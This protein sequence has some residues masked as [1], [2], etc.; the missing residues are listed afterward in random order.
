MKKYQF[1]SRAYSRL[2]R[3]STLKSTPL[4]LPSAPSGRRSLLKGAAGT[5]RRNGLAE[6]LEHP[7]PRYGRVTG[8]PLVSSFPLY[9][10]DMSPLLVLSEGHLDQQGVL[11]F[12]DADLI[13]AA[14]N[15]S[16][17]YHPSNIA[18]YALAHWNAYLLKGAEV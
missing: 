3:K 9:P 16:S 12:A 8:K 18:Q 1:M 15:R 7:R 13:I 17:L 10:L 4:A 5:A 6:K 11:C 2:Q 14:D